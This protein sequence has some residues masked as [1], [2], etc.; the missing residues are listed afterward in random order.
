M[1]STRQDAP[2]E[3]WFSALLV[4]LV[5]SAKDPDFH[6]CLRSLVV[7]KSTGFDDATN[8]AREIG[9]QRAVA[10]SIRDKEGV[11]EVELT[12]CYVETLDAIGPEIV[13][14]EVW[15]ALSDAVED[16]RVDPLRVPS[17]TI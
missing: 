6:K 4:F 5:D 9:T 8:K 3:E 7:F 12:F 10:E 15:S 13:G 14:Q 1:N 11:A 2:E 17:Q 16:I